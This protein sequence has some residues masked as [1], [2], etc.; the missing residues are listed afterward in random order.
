[1]S[2]IVVPSPR[3]GFSFE[4]AFQLW[5]L[6]LTNAVYIRNAYFPVKFVVFLIIFAQ[7]CSS[8]FFFAISLA[9]S[10]VIFI[11]LNLFFIIVIYVVLGFP[12]AVLVIFMGF[13]NIT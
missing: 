1:M 4:A 12:L 10:H 3:C 11:S 2:K 9:S 13:Q 8:G 6:K 5:G 7:H